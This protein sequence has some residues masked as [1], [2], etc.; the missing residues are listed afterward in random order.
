[1]RQGGNI[2][3]D[4]IHT[5]LWKMLIFRERELRFNCL[6]PQNKRCGREE[7]DGRGDQRKRKE[8]LPIKD[9]RTLLFFGIFRRP[10]SVGRSRQNLG[11]VPANGVLCGLK[12]ER[13]FIMRANPQHLDFKLKPQLAALVPPP[14]ARRQGS[15]VESPLACALVIDP[16]LTPAF[17]QIF[18]GSGIKIII[19]VLYSN[20]G[21]RSQFFIRKEYAGIF[22]R[23]RR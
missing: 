5:A 22:W 20:S 21:L 12:I 13:R 14:A 16:G 10:C 11:L 8:V 17:R 7:R 1:M 23:Q 2:R 4:N 9:G 6:L 15:F 18:R 19:I 3:F